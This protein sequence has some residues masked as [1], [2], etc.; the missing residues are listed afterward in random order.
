MLFGSPSTWERRTTEYCFWERR[1]H[2]CICYSAPDVL[3]FCAVDEYDRYK[4][5]A[6]KAMI[7]FLFSAKS[8]PCAWKASFG[9]PFMILLVSVHDADIRD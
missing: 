7:M 5:T 3:S 9:L 1:R 4:Q 8:Y 2:G 6:A